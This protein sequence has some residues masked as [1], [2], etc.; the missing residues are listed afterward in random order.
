MT[1][2]FWTVFIIIIIVI[3]V[4][5][6]M[7]FAK[8]SSG[9]LREDWQDY[10]RLPFDFISTGSNPMNF[11]RKDLYRKPYDYPYRFFS[12]YPVPSV[13]YHALL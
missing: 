13:Q 3:F 11:Y 6:S 7:A 4:F 5:L 8:L 9:R 1:V 2:L 12:S 10:M